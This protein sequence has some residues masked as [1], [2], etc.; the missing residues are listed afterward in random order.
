MKLGA[1]VAVVLVATACSDG[2]TSNT[3]N[4]P[5]IIIASDMPAS[6]LDTVSG[7]AA[8]PAQQAIAFAIQQQVSVGGFRLGYMPFDDALTAR[9]N[10]VR[11]VQNVKRMIRDP[12]VLGMIGPFNS[13]IAFSEIRIA[14]GSQLAM[15]SPSNTADCLTL[16]EPICGGG[17]SPT[18]LRPSG[19]NNYFRI[20]APDPLQGRAMA[21][22]ITRNLNLT[23]VAIF[24]EWGGAGRLIIKEFEREF[25]LAHGQVVFRQDLRSDT[26]DFG[27][28]L[29]KANAVQAEAVYAVG[30]SVDGPICAAAAQ[31]KLIMPG[32]RFLGTDGFTGDPQCMSDA[33]DNAEV[34]IGTL[35]DVDPRGTTDPAIKKLVAA[36]ENVYPKASDVS[37]Y[38][39]AAYD[40]A[41]IL[42]DAIG[43]AIRKNGGTRPTRAQVV[44]AIAETNNFIGVTGTY[45]FDNNG[46]AL[47][48]LS[49][50]HI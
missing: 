21:R 48:P 37:I 4:L 38:T 34:I 13:A 42:I 39:F 29:R 12:K 43:R 44:A 50:I 18:D 2:R 22:Y 17:R 31:M 3:G 7:S 45:S 35:S 5:E 49:L 46:D 15:V 33:A 10:Q 23:R 6:A 41:R 20:A 26:K 24:N 9:Q 1:W 8:L 47:S 11:G 25:G 27:D 40:C 14:N 32:N 28:F 16:I 19:T 36:Y 30:D